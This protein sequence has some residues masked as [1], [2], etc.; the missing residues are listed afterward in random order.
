M[1]LIVKFTK[2]R[3]TFYTN[4]F[5]R[6][7][8]FTKKDFLLAKHCQKAIWLSKYSADLKSPED[9]IVQMRY[10]QKSVVVQ[11]A[12]LLFESGKIINAINI[13]NALNETKQ[14]INQEDDFILFGAH[15]LVDDCL[16]IIDVLE[17][18]EGQY[19]LYNIRNMSIFKRSYAREIA[20]DTWVLSKF[21]INIYK[22]NVI[23][24][25]PDYSFHH[26][27]N[28]KRLFFIRNVSEDVTKRQ[29]HIEKAV[30]DVHQLLL[31]KDEPKMHLGSYCKRPFPCP[32]YGYCF[33]DIPNHSVF[34]IKGLELQKK[35][36][37]AN[38][39]IVDI[40]DVKQHITLTS[41]QEIQC[42]AELSGNHYVDKE[43]LAL[44]LDKLVY[45]RIYLDFE[46]IQSPIPLWEDTIPFQQIP[47]QFSIHI[48]HVKGGELEHIEYLTEA[49]GDPRY[50]LVAPL[51]KSL[52]ETGSIIAYNSS[53]EGQVFS[54]LAQ[55]SPK[56]K[57]VFKNARSRLVDLME[58][59][60][61]QYIY[62][63][64][65]EGGNSIKKIAPALIENF[66]YDDLPI[67]HGEMA[68]QS[69][70][71]FLHCNDVHEKDRLKQDL[72][73]YCK[74]DTLAM[75]LIVD[76]LESYLS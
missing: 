46:A 73:T 33:K 58:P 55:I 16:A 11:H 28:V 39:K 5:W 32:F 70:Q 71:H 17:R 50:D 53:F 4:I 13:D 62:L 59:F 40:K 49:Q 38:N 67:A 3:Y 44:F 10:H 61:K 63:R 9:P 20:Y 12:R 75:A 69:F 14:F 65:M 48:Q 36:E 74:Y 54:E 35:F 8:V 42:Q 31:E 7:T 72:L 2:T 68:S 52:P 37:L 47:F 76:K 22:C 60:F 23:Y 30:T 56:H 24:I 64:E 66:S 1:L 6:R 41:K 19:Y 45:P 26:T 51:L 43:K 15:F 18:K 34:T 27:L 25:N 29:R 21:G 57:W